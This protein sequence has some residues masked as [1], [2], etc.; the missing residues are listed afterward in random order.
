VGWR[1]AA[2][3]SYDWLYVLRKDGREYLLKECFGGRRSV[4][5]Q[6]ADALGAVAESG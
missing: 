2:D 1:R 6:D 4:N 5:L 3:N